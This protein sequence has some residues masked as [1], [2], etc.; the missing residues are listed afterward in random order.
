MFVFLLGRPGCG[1]SEI[2]RQTVEKL[3]QKGGGSQYKNFIRLDDFPKLWSIFQEDEKTGNWIYCKK[4]P[5]GGYKVTDDTVWD[6]ILT[7]LNNDLKKILEFS[8]SS[9]Q[10]VFVE[11]SRP[12]YVQALKNFSEDI[13]KDSIVAYIDCSFETCWKRNVRRHQQ[14]IAAGTDDH[15]V[16]RE[17]MEKTYLYDDKDE[18]LKFCNSVNIP[19]IVITTDYEGTAHLEKSTEKLAELLYSISRKC[20]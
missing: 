10:I 6:R 3:K 7:E 17:E 13:L 16:S 19:T 11:F 4:T 9:N 20:L 5:D 2:Y 15:L 8:A 18:L 1:K 12:N 14:A